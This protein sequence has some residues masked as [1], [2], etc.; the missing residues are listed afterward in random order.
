MLLYCIIQRIFIP[1]FCIFR[2]SVTIY[3]RTDVPQ[4]A[5][6]SI[7]PHKPLPP[8]CWYFRLQEIEK[9]GFKVDPQW[10]NYTKFHPNPSSGS[11]DESRRQIN[12]TNTCTTCKERLTTT[13]R[14][15]GYSDLTKEVIFGRSCILKGKRGRR[16]QLWGPFACLV[17]LAPSTA[18]P[19]D[20]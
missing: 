9:Y 19:T 14:P 20:V 2:K 6:V 11:R 18:H 13:W 1:K 3:H 4:L 15:A 7:P 16:V 8:P 10:Y 12:M 17:A 5:L